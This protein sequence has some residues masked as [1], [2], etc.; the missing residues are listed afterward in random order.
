MP[1][2]QASLLP[3]IPSVI[4]IHCLWLQL[5]ELIFLPREA[6]L[7]GFPICFQFQILFGIK[8]SLGV[9]LTPSACNSHSNLGQASHLLSLLPPGHDPHAVECYT[10]RCRSRRGAS[11]FGRRLPPRAPARPSASAGGPVAGLPAQIVK[12]TSPAYPT[13]F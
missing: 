11:T 7:A 12:Q 13:P 8:S 1:G 6:S 9:S 3:G 4:S 5:L 2:P 10:S